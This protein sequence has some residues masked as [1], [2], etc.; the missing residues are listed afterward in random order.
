MVDHAL[1]ELNA[2]ILPIK[3][4]CDNNIVMINTSA[5]SN[6]GYNCFSI[7]WFYRFI[8]KSIKNNGFKRKSRNTVWSMLIVF[9][10]TTSNVLP[11]HRIVV[12]FAR[13]ETVMRDQKRR[14]RQATFAPP[15]NLEN[16]GKRLTLQLQ[17]F[18]LRDYIATAP[19]TFPSLRTHAEE[20]IPGEA[21][22]NKRDARKNL[23][24]NRVSAS[25]TKFN[26]VRHSHLSFHGN[27][28]LRGIR[29]DFKLCIL[30]A[31]RININCGIIPRSGSLDYDGVLQWVLSA[32]SITVLQTD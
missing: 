30:R 26:V 20:M 9:L 31:L 12:I 6:I 1:F 10:R 23:F 27:D 21:G 19:D 22:R 14:S 15:A 32:G 11:Q 5:I 18:C 25:K 8:S 28:H 24:A 13:C 29:V 17:Y 4:F 7:W 16:V 2:W 3:R